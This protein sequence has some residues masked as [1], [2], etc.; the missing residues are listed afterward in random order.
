LSLQ[1]LLDLNTG[2]DSSSAAEPPK[3]AAL[4]RSPEEHKLKISVSSLF[5]SS[6]CYTRGYLPKLMI[7]S[8]NGYHVQRTQQRVWRLEGRDWREKSCQ[9]LGPA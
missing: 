6:H 2:A 1:L 3:S 9:S 7:G 5:V 4:S 8:N